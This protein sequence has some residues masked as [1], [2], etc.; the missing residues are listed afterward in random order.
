MRS[1][2][3]TWRPPV[4]S[5]ATMELN[6]GSMCRA[7]TSRAASL[8][9]STMGSGI[10]TKCARPASELKPGQRS[11]LANKPPSSPSVATTTGR[12]SCAAARNASRTSSMRQPMRAPRISIFARG[13]ST[14]LCGPEAAAIGVGEDA[15]FADQHP[16]GGH[17]GGEA[18][19]DGERGLKRLQ[20]AVVDAD[21]PVLQRQRARQ[22]LLVVHF[23]QHVEAEIVRRLVERA[24]AI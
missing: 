17:A 9:S 3:L 13:A 14:G 7:L 18:L 23:D 5:T 21:Q 20:I 24:R 8:A 1:T 4:S 10:S 12:P 19:A 15:A 2:S 6:A 16:V 11:T 22:F